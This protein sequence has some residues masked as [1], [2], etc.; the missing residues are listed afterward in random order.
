MQLKFSK[1]TLLSNPSKSLITE[2][3]LQKLRDHRTASSERQRAVRP[4]HA[5]PPPPSGRGGVS[6]CACAA[7]AAARSRP[8]RVYAPASSSVS[9]ALQLMTRGA[10]GVPREIKGSVQQ[11]SKKK[12]KIKCGDE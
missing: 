2:N 10:A 4:T 8:I 1:I 5:P 12:R 11:L 6:E 9:S 3:D 7:A